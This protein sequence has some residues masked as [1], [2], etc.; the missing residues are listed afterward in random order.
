MKAKDTVKDAVEV[1]FGLAANAGGN[2]LTSLTSRMFRGV[3]LDIKRDIQDKSVDWIGFTDT[4]GDNC[5]LKREAI[6]YMVCRK[7]KPLKKPEIAP[8]VKKWYQR[9]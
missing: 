8:V 9:I 4:D 2:Y 1:E 3:F 5:L 7:P 6:A